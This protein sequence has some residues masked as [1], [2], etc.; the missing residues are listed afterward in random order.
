MLNR[1]GATIPDGLIFALQRDTV[2]N[3][4]Q[5][6]LRPGKRPRPLVLRANVGDC[7]TITFTNAIPSTTFTNAQ[8]SFAKTGTTEVSLHVQGMEWVTGPGDD[9]SFVGK[10]NSSLASVTPVPAN[11]PP[12]TQTYS[13]YAKAEGTFLFYTMGDTTS[14]GIQL[15]RGLFGALNV[16]PAGAEWYRSQVTAT[17]LA[18]AT[19]NANNLGNAEYVDRTSGGHY[20]PGPGR[21]ATLSTSVKF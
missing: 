15:T 1:L 3:G 13:L 2:Q 20:I 17:D 19:Y 21:S 5:I 14:Q 10:N 8:K 6:Q 16:Q 11:M 18:N 9:G 4:N 7:L 12:N